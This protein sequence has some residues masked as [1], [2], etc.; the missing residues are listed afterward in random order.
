MTYFTKA[1]IQAMDK[2]YRVNLVNSLTGFKSA[3]L[4]G[5]QS[6]DKQTNLAIISSAFH[7]G[8]DPALIGFIN[9]PASVD[10]HT[11]DNLLATEYYTLNHVNTDIIKQAHQTS[12]RYPKEESE[13]TATGLTECWIDG[14]EAPF[15]EQSLVRIGLKYV[16]HHTLL[17]NTVLVIG[18]IVLVDIPSTSI[19]VDGLVNIEQL[20][21]VAVSGL[22]TY[23]DTSK[24]TRLSYAKPRKKLQIIEE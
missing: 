15:V 8:A 9:R 11:L 16:E 7:L 23:H 22:D 19:G 3:N 4:I 21:T 10:R 18:E 2:S 24:I 5:T 1:D 17:N 14:F 20:N 6:P 12:A 13:F